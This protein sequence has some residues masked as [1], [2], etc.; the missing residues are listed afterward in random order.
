MNES[1][2]TI[3]SS[4]IASILGLSPWSSPWDVWARMHGLTEST[5]SLATA[6]GHILEPAIGMHYA[7]LNNVSIEKGPEYEAITGGAHKTAV[8]CPLTT[9]RNASGRWQ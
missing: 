1:I 6:R 5:S 8:T 7:D 2:P 4:S 3:G 9:P